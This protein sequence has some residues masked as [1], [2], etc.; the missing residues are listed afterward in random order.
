MTDVPKLSSVVYEEELHAGR[1]I[2]LCT[3]IY[4]LYQ[5]KKFVKL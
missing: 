5:K 4:T 2:I 1:N 3:Y